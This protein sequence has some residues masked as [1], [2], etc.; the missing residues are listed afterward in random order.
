[1]KIVTFGINSYIELNHLK[2]QR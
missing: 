1:M 2:N